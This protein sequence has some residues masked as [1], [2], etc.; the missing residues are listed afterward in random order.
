MTTPISKPVRE[1]VIEL[2]EAYEHFAECDRLMEH[3]LE[4]HFLQEAETAALKLAHYF[5]ELKE[6]DSGPAESAPTPPKEIK[7]TAREERDRAWQYWF[8]Q[9]GSFEALQFPDLATRPSERTQEQN[10]RVMVRNI[11]REFKEQRP[12]INFWAPEDDDGTR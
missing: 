12:D 2:L 1:L 4:N 8:E 5:R 6:W 10:L 9:G 11:K 3:H 7:L